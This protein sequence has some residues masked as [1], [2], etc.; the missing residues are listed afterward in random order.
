[1]H[2]WQRYYHAWLTDPRFVFGGIGFGVGGAGIMLM[3]AN[4]FPLSAID[5]IFFSVLFLLLALHRPNWGFL[6]LVATLPLETVNMLP[7]TFGFSLRPYQWLLVI[8]V[9]ALAFRSLSKRSMLTGLHIVPQDVWLALIPLGAILSGII[10]GGEGRHFAII[11]LSFY[12]L[13]VLGRIFLRT[14]GDVEVAGSTLLSAG[15]ASLGFGLFQ[16]IAFENGSPV[17]TVMLGRPNGT[18]A[19]PDWLGFFAVVMFFVLFSYLVR[20]LNEQSEFS[21]HRLLR[22]AAVFLPITIVMMTLILTVSR[23]AW[24]AAVIAFIVWLSITLYTRCV[25]IQSMLQSLQ[26]TLIAFVVAIFIISDFSLTRF[27]LINRAGSTATGLQMI[28]VACPTPTA[29]PAQ[30]DSVEELRDYGCRHIDLEERAPLASEGQSIQTVE[31]SDPN[32]VIRREIYRLSWQTIRAHP[33]FG[34][35]WGNIQT[36]LGQDG[37]GTAYN[38]SNLWLEVWLGAGVFG[39]L[40]LAGSLG[41]MV[42][43]GVRV[44]MTQ[45]HQAQARPNIVFL[46]ALL[47]AFFIFNLFNAGLLI[48]YVWI[49]FACVPALTQ[50]K[51]AALL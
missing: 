23:S 4:V 7:T 51:K 42:F 19:E 43:R 50:P 38:A 11:I 16:N 28:T 6:V 18:F 26:V 33:L 37:Q 44:L 1:M 8:V 39:L 31:R 29:L 21:V 5:L 14:A 40:G 27:D 15:L 47:V 2:V 46:I 24:L 20:I 34:I 48:G 13:Y 9:C 35:G 10:S 32:V 49:G 3:L 30:I 22:V 45:K 36:V 41:L 12:A 25:P 17:A